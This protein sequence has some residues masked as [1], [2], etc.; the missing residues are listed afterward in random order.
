MKGK[1]HARYRHGSVCVCGKPAEVPV[2]VHWK[3]GDRTY[4]YCV[5]C[6][7][8]T[9]EFVEGVEIDMEAEA[10]STEERDG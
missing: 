7:E 3:S 5:E 9:V 6:A 8:N 10:A 4:W 2:K 1:S